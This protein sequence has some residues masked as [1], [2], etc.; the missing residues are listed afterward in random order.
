MDKRSLRHTISAF[1][2]FVADRSGKPSVQSAFSKRLVHYYLDMYRTMA[3]L[4]KR[5]SLEKPRMVQTLPCVE[6]LEV[7]QNEC[8]C[9]PKSGYKF[10]KSKYPLPEIASGQLLFVNSV[11]GNLEF[12]FVLWNNFHDHLNDR[13]TGQRT[14]RYYTTRIIDN[15]TYLYLYNTE[16]TTVAVT[17]SFTDPIEVRAFPRCGVDQTY[18]CDPLDEEFVIDEE[19]KGVVFRQAYEHLV[20]IR[21]QQTD[22][23]NN[24]K[25]DTAS[26][27]RA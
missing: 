10:F 25:D 14:A 27:P 8:P 9:I 13:Y 23:I 12:D 3:M 19:L 1:R 24:D 5:N 20:G 4:G 2:N 22:T 21:A 17:A 11:L 7:D 26:P 16:L 18:L 6:V 15:K